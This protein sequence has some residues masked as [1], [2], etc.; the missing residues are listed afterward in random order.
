MIHE[1]LIRFDG[2]VAEAL[3]DGRYR[4]RFPNAHEVTA[5]AD[6]GAP[7]E[8][9]TVGEPITV[10]ISPYDMNVGR[11]IFRHKESRL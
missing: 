5:D 6:P 8:T 10:E 7:R 2:K 1:R 3:P 11:L 4:V 9:L